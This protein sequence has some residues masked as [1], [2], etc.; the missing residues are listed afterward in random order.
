MGKLNKIG[1]NID[2]C[3]ITLIIPRYELNVEPIF[4]R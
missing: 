3:G 1:P 4:T 2:H